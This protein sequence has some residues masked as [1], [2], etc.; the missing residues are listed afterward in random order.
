MEIFLLKRAKDRLN[1]TIKN[2]DKRI[3]ELEEH[4][5]MIR[6]LESKFKDL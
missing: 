6:E 3:N 5:K 2:K 1:Q 4:S